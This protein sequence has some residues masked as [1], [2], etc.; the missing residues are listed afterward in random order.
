MKKTRNAAREDSYACTVCQGSKPLSEFDKVEGRRLDWCRECAPIHIGDHGR[1]NRNKEIDKLSEW[2]EKE[3][4]K[5]PCSFCGRVKYIHAWYKR[6][7]SEVDF[8]NHI[9]IRAFELPLLRRIALKTTPLC[10]PCSEVRD[11]HPRLLHSQ[12][13]TTFFR[14]RQAALSKDE[15]LRR[16][17][18]IEYK[19]LQKK[20]DEADR[21]WMGRVEAL[22][23]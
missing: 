5:V 16:R 23:K 7:G 11:Q 18:F 2:L 12:L 6:D 9:H 17:L 8:L 21:K 15:R 14:L 3:R 10:K 20:V 19:T 1:E 4:E 13:E 22:D